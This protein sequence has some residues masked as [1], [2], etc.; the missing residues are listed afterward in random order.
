MCVTRD[1][2]LFRVRGLTEADIRGW[3]KTHRVT[4]SL[5]QHSA[6]R[7]PCKPRSLLGTAWVSAGRRDKAEAQP[8]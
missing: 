2:N 4:R 8:K 5:V 3:Y 7:C 6:T 1:T